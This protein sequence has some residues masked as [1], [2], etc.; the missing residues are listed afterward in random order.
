MWKELFG[1]LM[2]LSFINDDR[3]DVRAAAVVAAAE[4]EALAVLVVQIIVKI[5]E[6]IRICR[7]MAA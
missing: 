6:T 1:P 2:K 3:K 4:E 5:L 7:T